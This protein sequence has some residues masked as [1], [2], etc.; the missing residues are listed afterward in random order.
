M[1]MNDMKCAVFSTNWQTG[2]PKY[3]WLIWQLAGFTNQNRPTF[4]PG[5]HILKGEQLTD[6][7]IVFQINKYVNLFLK[8][9]QTYYGIFML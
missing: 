7:S 4:R 9:M 3:N 5:M 8:Y 2:V 6:C 1:M